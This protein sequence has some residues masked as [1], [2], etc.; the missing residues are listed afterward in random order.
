MN[1]SWG[2]QFA[3]LLLRGVTGIGGFLDAKA[4]TLFSS[5]DRFCSPSSAAQRSLSSRLFP[6]VSCE[7]RWSS[8]VM[9]VAP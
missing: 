8:A 7:I 5:E 6:F 9:I 2:E 1:E 3:S 4:E